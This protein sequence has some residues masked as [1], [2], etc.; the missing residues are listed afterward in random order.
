MEAPLGRP[1]L[2]DVLTSLKKLVADGSGA[3]SSG[4]EEQ[5]DFKNR[6]F[7]SPSLRIDDGQNFW[8]DVSRGGQ[9]LQDK[10]L[11][12]ETLISKIE[13]KGDTDKAGQD[14]NVNQPLSELSLEQGDEAQLSDF[15]AP[16]IKHESN[17]QDT[18]LDTEP[19]AHI[20]I[21]ATPVYGVNPQASSSLDAEIT[22]GE[23]F[24]PLD[25][26]MLRQFISEVIREDLR[27]AL[28]EKIT[29]NIRKL[30]RGELEAMLSSSKNK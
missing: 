19:E 22:V 15:D 13:R 5:A 10:I 1:E 2:S 28:G 12:L 21:E 4:P 23:S 27:G 20:E 11:R 24:Q 25:P 14:Q 8:L 7:L 30:V 3:E 29:S 18:I 6:L 16:V 17:E 9:S 26:E